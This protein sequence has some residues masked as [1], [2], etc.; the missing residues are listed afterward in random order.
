METD[1]ELNQVVEHLKGLPGFDT[2][3]LHHLLEDTAANTVLRI[4]ARFSVTLEESLFL[5]EKGAEIEDQTLIWKAAHKIAGS[6]E[7]LGFKEFGQ[8]SKRLSGHLKLSSDLSNHVED[9]AAY[10]SDVKT[11]LNLIS[12]SFPRRQSYL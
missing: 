2:Y 11:L 5:L 6:A 9:I 8:K 7:M 12:K 3:A 10:R 4:L 1:I